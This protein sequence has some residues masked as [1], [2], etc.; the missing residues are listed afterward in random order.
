MGVV[1]GIFLRG[2]GSLG[3]L[4]WVPAHR[5]IALE[6][7]RTPAEGI[8]KVGPQGERGGALRGVAARDCGGQA[9]GA[10]RCQLGA[11]AAVP[12][13]E[14][15]GRRGGTGMFPEHRARDL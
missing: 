2:C 9:A 5:Q 14:L 1:G 12:H 10:G 11:H 4:S 15:H 13:L 3:Q 8:C 7:V 6:A